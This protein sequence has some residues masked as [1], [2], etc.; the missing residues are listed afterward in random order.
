MTLYFILKGK[1]NIRMDDY[2]QKIIHT[3]PQKMGSTDMDIILAGDNL[4]E[5]GSCKPLGKSQAEYFHKMV[6]K[7]LFLLNILIPNIQPTIYVLATSA[8]SPN[9]IDCNKLVRILK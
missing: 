6:V 2:V 1:F 7:A 8:I 3:F 5:N 4:F 9:I